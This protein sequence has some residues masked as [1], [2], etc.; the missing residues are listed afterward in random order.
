VRL[1][2]LQHVPFEDLGNIKIWAKEKRYS[3]SKTLLYKGEKL[4]SLIG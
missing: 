1:H 4:L 3:I 2:Y